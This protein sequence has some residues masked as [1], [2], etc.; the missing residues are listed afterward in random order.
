MTVPS[1]NEPLHVLLLMELL[2]KSAL[3]ALPFMSA[4]S[5]NNADFTIEE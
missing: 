3:T 2:N 5:S 4:M 1:L